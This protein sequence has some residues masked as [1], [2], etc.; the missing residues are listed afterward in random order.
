LQ[1]HSGKHENKHI[2]ISALQHDRE[3]YR[4][5]LALGRGDMYRLLK[6]TTSIFSLYPRLALWRRYCVWTSHYQ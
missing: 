4:A 2:I 5:Y 6:A 1:L 3:M